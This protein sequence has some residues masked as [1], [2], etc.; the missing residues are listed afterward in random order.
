M[1]T[2]KTKQINETEPRVRDRIIIR[3]LLVSTTTL[4]LGMLVSF[5]VGGEITA[6]VEEG[7]FNRATDMVEE[8]F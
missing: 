6:I 8:S 4:G 5:E 3:F 1:D 2:A 7:I